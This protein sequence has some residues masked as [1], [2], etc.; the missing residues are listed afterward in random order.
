M[1]A[2]FSLFLFFTI[3]FILSSLLSHCLHDLVENAIQHYSKQ[4]SSFPSLSRSL[5]LSL[6]P[7]FIYPLHL[8]LQFSFSFTFLRN[9]DKKKIRLK[10]KKTG[11]EEEEEKKKKTT[12]EKGST[13]TSVTF[14]VTRQ[15][16]NQNRGSSFAPPRW[17]C[18]K[19][20]DEWR[21]SLAT[22]QRF[23]IKPY[24]VE[25]NWHWLP[26]WATAADSS[27]PAERRTWSTACGKVTGWLW[28][29]G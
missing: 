20:P 27:D 21:A 3:S 28:V 11:D 7:S 13:P 1:R 15:L 2:F 29:R 6:S 5:A 23:M 12:K 26:I 19:G 17:G 4:A 16:E 24:Y 22:P 9:T 8:S 25:G 18:V 14:H 10:K